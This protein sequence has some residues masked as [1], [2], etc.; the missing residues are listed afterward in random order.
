MRGLSG[1]GRVI[2]SSLLTRTFACYMNQSTQVSVTMQMK[3][4]YS[5]VLL[6]ECRELLWWHPRTICDRGSLATL[7]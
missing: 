7:G 6:A 5:S 2:H 3:L 4:I 1:V